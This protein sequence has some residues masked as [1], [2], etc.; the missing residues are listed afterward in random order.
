MVFVL[1]VFQNKS[2]RGIATPK[3]DMD[4][5]RERLKVA[6]QIAKESAR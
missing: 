4:L 3:V 2:K 5:I 1:H 6:E